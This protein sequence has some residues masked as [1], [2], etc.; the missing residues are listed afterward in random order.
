MADT[1]SFT[2]DGSH[3]LRCLFLFIHKEAPAEDLLPHLHLPSCLLYLAG[4]GQLVCALIVSQPFCLNLT[5]STQSCPAHLLLL[6]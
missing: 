6:H 1:L 2:F 5:A 4:A 3:I